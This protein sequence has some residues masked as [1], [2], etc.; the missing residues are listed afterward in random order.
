M[1]NFSASLVGMG[2]RN[3]STVLAGDDALD[4]LERPV[5]L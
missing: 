3:C 1:Y 2:D 4:E 5:G